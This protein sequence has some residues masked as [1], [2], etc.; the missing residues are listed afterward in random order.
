MDIVCNNFG[1]KMID[2]CK[3]NNFFIVNGW[4]GNDVGVG[5]FMCKN[6]SIVDYVLCSLELF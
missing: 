1:Y 4:V 2:F 5:V 6:S 3:N